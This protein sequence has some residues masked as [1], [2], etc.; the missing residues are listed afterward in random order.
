M[1]AEACSATVSS[2]SRGLNAAE[3]LITTQSTV[4]IGAT[5]DFCDVRNLPYLRTQVD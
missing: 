4:W 2:F 5:N 3:S 1:D